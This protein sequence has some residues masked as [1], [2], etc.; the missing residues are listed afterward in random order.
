[1]GSDLQASVGLS[2]NS[3]VNSFNFTFQLIPNSVAATAQR[4]GLAGL[5]NSFLG[6]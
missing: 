3:F 2:Y 5:G 6:R 1:M 4:G